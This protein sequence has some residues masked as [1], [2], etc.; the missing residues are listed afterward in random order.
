MT[1]FDRTFVEIS[2]NSNPSFNVT[3]SRLVHL[4]KIRFIPIGD[5]GDCLNFES[6]TNEGTDT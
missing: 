5:D 3:R 1:A 6:Y 2:R 4:I